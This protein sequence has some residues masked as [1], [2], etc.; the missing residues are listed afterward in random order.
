MPKM[1]WTLLIS[2]LCY[3][4]IAHRDCTFGSISKVLV[5]GKFSINI[6][7]YPGPVYI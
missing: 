3:S 4:V 2:V 7:Y 5:K 6:N 1:I